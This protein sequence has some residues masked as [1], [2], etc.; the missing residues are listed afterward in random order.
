MRNVI[1]CALAILLALVGAGMA[2]SAAESAADPAWRLNKEEL[3]RVEDCS[4]AVKKAVR[5]QLLQGYARGDPEMS[6]TA[7]AV[8]REVARSAPRAVIGPAAQHFHHASADAA[9]VRRRLYTLISD[10]A[11]RRE[12]PISVLKAALRSDEPRLRRRAVWTA[13]DIGAPAAE[14][15]PALLDLVSTGDPTMRRHVLEALR[16]VGVEADAVPR[17]CE[18]LHSSHFAV[19]RFAIDSLAELGPRAESA[20]P[21]LVSIAEA[22]DEALRADIG[23]VLKQVKTHNSAPVVGD[24]VVSCEEGGSAVVE[25]PFA[26]WD[27]MPGALEACIEVGPAQGTLENRGEGRFIYHSSRGFAGE[28]SFICRVS[29]GEGGVSRARATVRIKPDTSPPGLEEVASGG[30]P[31]KLRLMFG[32]PV[33]PGAAEDVANYD[34]SSDVDV[35]RAQLGEYGLTV[36]LSTTPLSEGENYRLTVRN[37]A[38]R[39]AAKNRISELRMQLQYYEGEN[40][41]SVVVA[42]EI[43]DPRATQA[44]VQ[45]DWSDEHT[46]LYTL[47]WMHAFS[48]ELGPGETSSGFTRIADLLPACWL[49]GAGRTA[50]GDGPELVSR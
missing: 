20:A 2:S 31:G 18:L 43:E 42:E 49:Q 11:G 8:L 34:L 27:S 37:I 47:G 10:L 50:E 33:S 4:L 46:S 39:A 32:E 1:R 12:F 5:P 7:R 19:Q 14:A 41:G 26:A 35:I 28:D 36:T 23:R 17:L 21:R 45:G 38:D 25:V 6:D 24:V 30:R 48:G 3:A 44:P 22:A 40:V 13:T 9:T 29:D 16:T 15:A